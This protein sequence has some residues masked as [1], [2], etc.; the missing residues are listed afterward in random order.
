MKKNIIILLLALSIIGF[1]GGYII[2]NSNLEVNGIGYLLIRIS[3]ALFYGMGALA[4]VFLILLFRPS[5]ISAWKKFAKWYIP[6]VTFIFIFYP[7]PSS[8]DFFSPYP[9]QVFQWLSVMYVIVSVLIIMF[10]NKTSQPM[11]VR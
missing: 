6:I 5:A 11:A 1:I 8:G 7:N 2:L 3:K 4:I 9:E 10:K